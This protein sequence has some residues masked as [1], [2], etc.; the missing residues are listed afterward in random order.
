MS[1]PPR[2]ERGQSMVEFALV[3]MVAFVVLFGII[4]FSLLFA[5]KITSTNAAR[6]AVRFAATHPTAWSSSASPPPDTI[7]GR[8]LSAAIPAVIVNDDAHITLSYVLPGP[9]AGVT[10]GQYSAATSSF[11]PASGYTQ[12][13]CVQPGSLIRI[14]VRYVYTFATPLNAMIGRTS[15]SV[16]ID[17]DA[18]E[19]EE[20]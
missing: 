16:T 7:Q 5:G 17:G 4:D 10:C 15:N 18:A 11:Q 19:L 2:R 20:R 6:N 14:H 1:S 8:L 12:A 13:T 9:G 3:A